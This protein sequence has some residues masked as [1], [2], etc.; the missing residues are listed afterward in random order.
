MVLAFTTTTN[1]GG[2]LKLNRLTKRVQDLLQIT[3]LYTVFDVHDSNFD[4]LPHIEI[5]RGD[6]SAIKAASALPVILSLRNDRIRVE[7]GVEDDVYRV[8][9]DEASRG[10]KVIIARPH[11]FAASKRTQLHAEVREFEELVNSRYASESDIHRFFEEH[12]NFLLGQ[13]YRQLH[14]K[15]LLERDEAGPLIP[16]FML[17]PFDDDLCDLLE[18]KLPHEPIVV[19]R[20]NRKRF[21][22][23]VQE[24]VAQLRTYRDYFDDRSRREEIQRRYGIRAYRPRMAVVIGRLTAMDP[25]EYRRIADGQKE[26]RIMTYDDLLKRARRFLVV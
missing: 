1:A 17:Q 11:V 8:Q 21:S 5:D 6:V 9:T 13:E 25:I 18:L 26:V 7:L 10:S 4:H 23:A 20:A 16:D 2:T 24:A 15:I 22:S 3:K 19:G 12:P 14:S